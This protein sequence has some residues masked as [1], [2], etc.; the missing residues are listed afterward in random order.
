M[1]TNSFAQV[2]DC[3]L[4][5]WMPPH[6]SELKRYYVAFPQCNPVLQ[7][8]KIEHIS[9]LH[10]IIWESYVQYW[11]LYYSHPFQYFPPTQN[12]HKMKLPLDF[13]CWITYSHICLFVYITALLK[14]TANPKMQNNDP[15]LRIKYSS[16]RCT[17]ICW[18]LIQYWCHS[19]TLFVHSSIFAIWSNDNNNRCRLSL[20][21]RKEYKYA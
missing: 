7:I 5:N 2:Y 3:F 13:W 20:S 6:F 21:L 14:S 4:W 17:L 16:S 10:N 12:F 9:P 11:R 19:S 1:A 8:Y 15:Y 18:Y